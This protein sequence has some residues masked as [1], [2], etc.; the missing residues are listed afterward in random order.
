MAV[1]LRYG[2]AVADFAAAGAVSRPDQG[3]CCAPGP[4]LG[5]AAEAEELATLLKVLADPVRIRL[6]HHIAGAAHGT[7]CACH[8]PD[9]LGISQPTLSHHLRRLTDA[10]LVTREQRG[11]WAH[12]TVRPGALAPVTALL[13]ALQ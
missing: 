5:D 12:Y 3:I 11:R 6:L 4:H 1:N 13:D 9:A 10:G 8:L 7:A 2:E